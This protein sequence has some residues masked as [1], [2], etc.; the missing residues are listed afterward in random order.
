MK[1]YLLCLPLAAAM[2][3]TLPACKDKKKTENT[4]TTTTQTAPPP[5]APVEISAD[6]ELQQKLPEVM[7]DFPGATATVAN[8]E[9]TVTGTLARERWMKLRPAL[10]ALHPKKVNNQLTLK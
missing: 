9:I 4:E 5:A 1:K 2:A 6:Q 8:G 10:D 7:K 3:L